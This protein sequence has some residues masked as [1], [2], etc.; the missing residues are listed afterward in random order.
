MRQLPRVAAAVVCNAH[1]LMRITSFQDGLFGNLL[2]LFALQ[3]H[4]VN[5]L[6]Q[7][8]YDLE[9]DV[10]VEFRQTTFR[11]PLCPFKRLWLEK[12]LK[13][14]LLRRQTAWVRHVLLCK[15]SAASSSL[16]DIASQQGDIEMLEFLHTR[17]IRGSTEALDSAKSL[18]VVEYLHD[19]QYA[20]TTAAMDI[21]ALRGALD[22]VRFLH[23]QRREGCTVLAMDFAA[24]NGHLDVLEFL[25]SHRREGYST[26]AMDMAIKRRHIHVVEFFLRHRHHT[27][28]TG[29]DVL[30]QAA[31]LV[32][33]H[34]DLPPVNVR[35]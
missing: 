15:P 23:E 4:L 26:M 2:P 1:L 31:A 30:Q 6:D 16:V 28:N 22:I 29:D 20:C 10:E 27:N 32:D 8:R 3:R 18:A 34:S 24:S 5:E 17:H 25:H 12:L 9:V 19:R 11:I 33:G 13:Q 21:A 35:G 14:A 7:R